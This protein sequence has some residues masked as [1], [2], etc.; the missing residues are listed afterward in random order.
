MKPKNRAEWRRLLGRLLKVTWLDACGDHFLEDEILTLA[1]IESVGWLQAFN[2]N[3][4]NL[5]AFRS[6]DTDGGWRYI[7][8]IPIATIEK[9]RLL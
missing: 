9:V 6:T 1:S 4:I 3:T 7:M 2:Q 8:A 5:A